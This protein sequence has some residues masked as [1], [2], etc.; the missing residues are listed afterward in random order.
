MN[1]IIDEKKVLQ[2]WVIRLKCDICGEFFYYYNQEQYMC[3]KHY[4]QWIL[5]QNRKQK[6]I[7]INK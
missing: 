7:K 1:I 4:E 6:L 3:P 2:K 5:K